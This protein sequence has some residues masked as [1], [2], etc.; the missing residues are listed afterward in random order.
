MSR[1][2]A[3][4]TLATISIFLLSA[5]LSQA[6]TTIHVPADQPTIQAGIIAASNGDT[7]LVAPG[8]YKENVN[9]QGKAIILRSSG[10]AKVTIIDGGGVAPVLTFSSNETSSSVLNGFTLQNGTS[11]FTSQYSGGGIF[12]SFASPTIKNN[13]IQ[14]NTACAGGAGIE[15]YF[16]SPLIQ[17]NTI[18]SNSQSGCSGGGGGGIE[19]GGASTVQIIGNVIQNNSWGGSG[20]GIFLNSVGSALIKNNVI[21]GNVGGGIA[22]INGVSG[23]AIVQNLISGNTSTGGSGVYW[24]NPPGVFVNNTIVD[25]PASGGSTVATDDFGT[26]VTVANNI[27]VA[28]HGATNALSCGTDLIAS[29]FYNNDIFSAN[30]P[31]YG[32]ICTDQTGMRGNISANP[33]FTGTSNFRLKAGSPA[34]DAG[35]NTVPDLPSTDVAGNPRIINGNGGTTA[36]VDMGAY[37]FLPV[38]LTPKSLNF[39]LQ[40]IGSSTS[41]TIKL[42]NA[43]TKVLNILS[44]SVSTGYSVS[45]CGSSVAAL[46]SC[47]LTVTF[48]PLT[49]GSFKG[50][51]SVKDNAGSSPQMVGLV[52]SAH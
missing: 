29:T 50:T 6:A 21:T 24:S 2:S 51:L 23:T 20:G 49:S 48:H 13:I 12:V 26:P 43:Q 8:M 39:G 10:G 46:A 5:T 36:I 3:T 47:N 44:F 16:G 4:C 33:K 34:I 31:A 19:A 45:G 17:G 42:T 27:I 7:I 28:I 9:F 37:E 32:G 14:N 35:S 40:V 52:G 1:H 11:T 22:M 38:V 15:V 25:G 30:G 18:K 41:K